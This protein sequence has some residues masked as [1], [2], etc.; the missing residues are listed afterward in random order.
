MT[1]F[2]IVCGSC[3]QVTDSLNKVNDLHGNTFALAGDCC[4]GL[5]RQKVKRLACKY[6]SYSIDGVQVASPRGSPSIGSIEQLDREI[7]E[8]KDT[9]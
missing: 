5:L 3:Q 6:G 2:T 9:S 7:N 8:L 1:K 4:I